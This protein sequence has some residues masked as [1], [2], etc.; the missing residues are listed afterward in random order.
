VSFTCAD[1]LSGVSVCPAPQIISDDGRRQIF[2]V[3]A[4]DLAGNQ[5]SQTVQISL[6]QT[7]P[8]LAFVYP[9]DGGL[10]ADAHPIVQLRLTDNLSLDAASL[11]LVADGEPVA[12]TQSGDFARCPL[13]S[14][15]SAE[16]ATHL[17]A[18]V[19]DHAGNITQTHITLALDSDGDGVPD[20]ADACPATPADEVADENGCGPSQ[21]DSD[22]DGF[23]DA[24]ELAAGS[25]P[26]DPLD[27][28]ALKI[29]SFSAA[30][31]VLTQPGATA[32]LF[33]QVQ[34]ARAIS[35]HNDADGT[36]LTGLAS[37]AGA[38]VN[39]AFTTRYSL[40]VDNGN[41]SL[42]QT[43]ELRLE[44]PPEPS[45]WQ[46]PAQ[47]PLTD[48]KVATS[49]S[50]S[51]DGSSYLGSFDGNFYKLDANGELAWT[52]E[53]AGLVKG[54][55]L[56]AGELI[57]VGANVGGLTHDGGAGR[58]YALDAD[59]NI[60]WQVDTDSA[61]IASPILSADGTTVFVASYGG[62]V[63]ARKAANGQL[64][65]RHQLPDGQKITAT[66]AYVPAQSALVVHGAG[67]K[68]YAL[69]VNAAS[70]DARLLWIRTLTP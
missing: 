7:P 63:L 59:K 48:E 27:Q 49:L 33:W 10:L 35:V 69:D 61:V 58:V 70:D 20:Y 26:Y 46:S 24:E 57:I 34:G 1:D 54:K 23:T 5:I 18:S 62:E 68:L 67:G 41:D 53:G 30:P 31:Q 52:L 15:L 8:E 38:T 28:P 55:A 16:A 66:P 22:S 56:F 65:W 45:L 42:S 36:A 13:S 51:P 21:R 29:L 43:L 2:S 32:Q 14:G 40:N 60:R 17:Q 64:L 12:C 3:T 4:E 39:P 44:L 47:A 11:Q 25:D 50:V 9:A 6:D 37:K 19:S